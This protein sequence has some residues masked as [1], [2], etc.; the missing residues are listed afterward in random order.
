LQLNSLRGV[1]LAFEACEEISIEGEMPGGINNIVRARI[2]RPEAF[3]LIKAF[4]LAERAKEKDAYDIAFVLHNYLPSL[5][6]FANAM[7][8]LIVDGL[9]AEAYQ[10][11]VEKFA[12]LESVGPSWSAKVAEESGENFGQARQAAFQDALHLFEEVRRSQQ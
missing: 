10:I 9:G 1:D 7:A 8:P 2:V 6:S 11:L 4:A 3:V 5:S 12:S